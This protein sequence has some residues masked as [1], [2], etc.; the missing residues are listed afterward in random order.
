MPWVDASSS[1]VHGHLRKLHKSQLKNRGTFS[2]IILFHFLYFHAA[3]ENFFTLLD[4]MVCQVHFWFLHTF[5]LR[6][7]AYS[8]FENTNQIYSYILLFYGVTAQ[9]RTAL[10]FS[11]HKK[12]RKVGEV[13]SVAIVMFCCNKLQ[14]DL[15]GLTA[16]S[17]IFIYSQSIVKQTVSYYDFHHIVN[18]QIKT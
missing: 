1:C 6:E 10:C 16:V 5:S 11:K 8:H 12:K 3:E 17:T 13:A 4:H 18:K 2:G 7:Q 9:N 14:N 15:K